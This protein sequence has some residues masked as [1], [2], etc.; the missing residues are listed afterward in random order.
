MHHIIHAVIISKINRIGPFVR[1]ETSHRHY[2][3]ADAVL[4]RECIMPAVISRRSRAVRRTRNKT[5]NVM[6]S[7]QTPCATKKSCKRAVFL[8]NV[9]RLATYDTSCAIERKGNFESSETS[10]P[11]LNRRLTKQIPRSSPRFLCQRKHVISYS[12]YR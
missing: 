5:A 6:M 11:R 3:K 2:I 8:H 9:S 7:K 10:L 1:Q 4:H 12:V